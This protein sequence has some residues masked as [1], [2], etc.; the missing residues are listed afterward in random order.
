MIPIS[1]QSATPIA[2]RNDVIEAMVA[3]LFTT[4]L[5]QGPGKISITSDFRPSRS[6]L[7]TNGDVPS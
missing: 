7:E 5:R 4:T 3:T 6:P 1:V 2:E